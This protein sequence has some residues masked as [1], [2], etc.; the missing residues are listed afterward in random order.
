[1]KA[2]TMAI[3]LAL[4]IPAWLSDNPGSGTQEV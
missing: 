1:M 4:M 2:R 3:I